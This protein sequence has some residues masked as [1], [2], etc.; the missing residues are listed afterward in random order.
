MTWWPKTGLWRHTNFLKLWAAQ[1]VSAIGSRITRTALPVIAILTIEASPNQIALLSAL[2]TGP[3]LLI[4]LL[5]GGYI[6]RS[7]KRSILIA[8]DVARAAL[9]F[10]VPVAAWL[11]GLSMI[12]LYMVAGLVGA[13]SALFQ[14]TDNA[15]LPVLIGKRELVEGNAKLEATEAVAE[16][17][18]PG[19]AGVLIQVLSGPLAL[20][21]DALTYLWSAI[22]LATI[23]KPEPRPARRDATAS[24][25]RDIV[26]GFR[27]VF[28]HALLGPLGLATAVSS[29]SFG[30]FVTLYMIFTL[31][32]LGLDPATVGI[33][34][35]FGGVGG[36]L[37]TILV[38]RLTPH[39][40]LGTAMILF[41]VL[42][43]CSQLLIPLASGP[44][45]L[46]IGL[47]VGHQIIGDGLMIAFTIQSVSLR[48]TVLPIS[49]LGRVNATLHVLGGGRLLA[50]L[51]VAGPI[52]TALG[53]RTA[54]WIGVS[55]GL[56]APLFLL[57][58]PI[59]T[60]HRMPREAGS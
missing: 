18:G 40:R 49:L 38:T 16:V 9:I 12:Q 4:G 35:G 3:G 25:A 8:S 53:V 20:V 57:I 34:I 47:L 5:A 50:G 17:T 27:A 54:V 29:L 21:V 51:L 60:L 43:H 33:L 37:G 19:L 36:F 11:G 15:Y 46:V 55:I 42:G 31:D 59:R 2:S 39:L 22:F 48:Q 58:S 1:A 10:T 44:E 32:T 28:G 24:V 56:I 14:I 45:W 23:D 13:A 30:F 41:M 26:T 7:A 52:A 6:D